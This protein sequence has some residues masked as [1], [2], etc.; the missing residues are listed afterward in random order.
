[1]AIGGDWR[2]EVFP[3]LR[4]GD[5]V[6]LFRRALA[7]GSSPRDRF[8]KREISWIELSQAESVSGDTTSRL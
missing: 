3:M 1:M 4:Y 7:T 2:L 6:G 8:E 5:A